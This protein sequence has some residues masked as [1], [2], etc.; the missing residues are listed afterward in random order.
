MADLRLIE[1]VIR[2]RVIVLACQFRGCDIECDAKGRYGKIRVARD[3]KPV[4]FEM[5]LE[6]NNFDLSDIKARALTLAQEAPV[7]ILVP[8]QDDILD[9]IK[10]ENMLLE[11]VNQI[12]A[13]VYG[14]SG[15]VLEMFADLPRK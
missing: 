11:S 14:K 1:K 8:D 15:E 2:Q 12:T 9:Q 10:Q 13:L 7:T 3:D 4:H 6:E 5:V